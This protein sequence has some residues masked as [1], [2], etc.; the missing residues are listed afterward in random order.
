L[1]PSRSARFTFERNALSGPD[2]LFAALLHLLVVGV[3]VTL[4]WWQGSREPEPMKRIEVQMISAKQLAKM[5]HPKA[6]PHKTAKKTKSEAKPSL[7]T[8]P[9]SKS[10]PV[11]EEP[12]DPFAPVESSS[13]R[14]D[15]ASSAPNR[16]LA[17]IMEQQL[18]S[19]EMDRYIAMMQAA[20][21]RN[22]KVPAGVSE[23]TPDPVVEVELR[24]DGSVAR[25]E[26]VKSSGNDALDRTL[27]AAIKA[28][29]PFQIPRQQ[30]E[31]F[32]INRIGFHPLK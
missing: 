22:W 18:S 8:K 29:A 1:S 6:A 10:K 9:S 32:R 24:P 12:F 3:I 17:N 7:K 23:S 4:V 26:V 5:Q 27:I 11:A 15:A 30:F 31:A 20:V 28:A 16:D 21:Q 13:D 25:I 2:L 19:Q 14:T